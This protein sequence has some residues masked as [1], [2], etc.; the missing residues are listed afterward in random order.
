M[1]NIK[2]RTLWIISLLELL[3]G[4]GLILACIY[5]DNGINKVMIILMTIDF[6]LLALTIQ[7]ASYKSFKY[8]SK[9]KVYVT[10]EYINDNDLSEKLDELK[11]E[12]R[13]RNYGKSYL[14]IEKRSAFKVVLV[15]DPV[16]YFNH[17]EDDE[18]T[19]PNKKLD[20]CLTFT[21]I[22]V[23]INS[24][25]ELREK[26]SDFTIQVEKV[27]YTAL[28]KIDDN[29]YLCHNYEEPNEKHKDDVNHLYEMLGFK[30]VVDETTGNNEL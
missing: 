8:K 4:V 15:T 21:A 26:L 7:F 3:V 19:E 6:L 18:N 28:E 1:I 30:E 24:N 14:K 11:F 16:G 22:E 23:F 27:Y 29:R 10:K 17:D 20:N 5:T 13:E 2:A 12:L 9:K 25:D